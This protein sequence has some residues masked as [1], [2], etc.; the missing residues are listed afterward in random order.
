MPLKTHDLAIDKEDVALNQVLKAAQS[1]SLM[2]ILEIGDVSH[3]TL[4][5]F[6]SH[7]L[8][9]KPMDNALQV[10]FFFLFNKWFSYIEDIYL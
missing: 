2:D 8:A 9:L 10:Y 7:D 3:A 5:N 1:D 4:S 6:L